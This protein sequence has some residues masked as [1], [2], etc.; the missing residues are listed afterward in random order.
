LVFRP[1]DINAQVIRQLSQLACFIF[2]CLSMMM[3]MMII[4][5][6]IH[7]HSGLQNGMLFYKRI[8][9]QQLWHW[10]LRVG[11]GWV[12]RFVDPGSSEAGPY[13]TLP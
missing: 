1:V 9:Y 3:I 11:S 7:H 13:L 6:H 4:G 12:L 10:Y 8:S 2:W 5:F